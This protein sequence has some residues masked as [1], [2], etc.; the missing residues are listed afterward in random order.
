M[1]DF[2]AGVPIT[3]DP[4][5]IEKELARLWKPATL[6]AGEGE[7]A[8]TRVCLLNLLVHLPDAAARERAGTVLSR[9]GRLYPS[10]L[11]LLTMA[12]AAPGAPGA[13]A[14]EQPQAASGG[15]SAS[16]TAVCHVTRPGSPPVC[17]EEIALSAPPGAF[18]L[19]KGSVPSLLV[20]DLPVV[21]V[22]FSRASED[23]LRAV[24]DVLDGVVFDSR[25]APLGELEKVARAAGST[26]LRVEDLAWRDTE[27]WRE[28]VSG[29]FDEAGA[30]GVLAGARVVEI[31]FSGEGTPAALLAGWLSSRLGWQVELSASAA[32]GLAATLRAGARSLQL[33]LR[34]RNDREASGAGAP[35]AAAVLSVLLCDGGPGEVDSAYVSVRLNASGTALRIEH[36]TRAACN[37]PREV[38]LGSRSDA[39]L[40]GAVLERPA[41]PALFREALAAALTLVPREE[42]PE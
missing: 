10:R 7:P 19:F 24:E 3:V 21:L 14:A 9:L 13:P 31:E 33:V 25:S 26:R 20:P 40:L 11:L 23:L 42:A 15:L 35:G 38:P 34:R 27:G 28:A 22:F 29:V 1:S 2:F 5:R 36:R 6:A 16:I 17:C 12:G 32:G 30:R 4:V 8:V 37:L 41:A 18:H 39:D